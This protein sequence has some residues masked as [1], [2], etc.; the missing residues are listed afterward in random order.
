MHLEGIVSFLHKL[1]ALGMTSFK[2][3]HTPENFN[4]FFLCTTTINLIE[5]VGG[6]MGQSRAVMEMENY[7]DIFLTRQKSC[8]HLYLAPFH[9]L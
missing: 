8:V 1:H 9:L 3:I 5:F 4:N 6:F 2:N 7:A